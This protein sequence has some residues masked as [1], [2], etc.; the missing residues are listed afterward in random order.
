MPSVVYLAERG[1]PNFEAGRSTVD[2]V[3]AGDRLGLG[4]VED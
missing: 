4:Q 2:V 3:R 1:S